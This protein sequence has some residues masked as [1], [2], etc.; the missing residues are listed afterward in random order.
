MA[1]SSNT[2]WLKEKQITNGFTY[3]LREYQQITSLGPF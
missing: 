1:L 2:Y 3:W